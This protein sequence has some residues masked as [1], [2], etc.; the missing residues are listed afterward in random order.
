MAN[1]VRRHGCTGAH[2]S[3]ARLHEQ[4][5]LDAAA[6]RLARGETL[7]Q[8]TAAAGYRAMTA[9]SIHL[10]GDLS[11]LQTEQMLVRQFCAQLAAP[12][13]ADLGV[14][15]RAGD[16]WVIAATPFSA[17]L[18]SDAQSADRRVLELVNAARAQGR[19]CGGQPFPPAAPLKFSTLLQQAALAHARDMSLHSYLEH[20]ARDGSTPAQRIAATGYEWRIV[21]ENIAAGPTS[22]DEVTRGWLASPE[23]CANLM[24]PRFTDTAVA[25]SVN[26]VSKQGVYWAQEFASPRT[27]PTH[28]AHP[29]R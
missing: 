19:S 21:G 15:R 17:P 12:T 10:S 7:Q 5:N 9:A 2:G 11:A 3:H 8:A 6:M 26:R 25:F 14:Y 4:P 29:T 24:D 18:L 22:A 28:D 27:H 16:L 20:T 23:H 13:T 1:A